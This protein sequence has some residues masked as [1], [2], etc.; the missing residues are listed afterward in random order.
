MIALNQPFNGQIAG[1]LG[2]DYMCMKQANNIGLDG[3]LFRAFLSS[4]Y[5]ALKYL[6]ASKYSDLPIANFKVKHI[7]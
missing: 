5:L 2:A 6:V 1:T 4:D 3:K 7:V